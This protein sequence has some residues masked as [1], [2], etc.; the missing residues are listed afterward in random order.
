[1]HFIHLFFQFDLFQLFSFN[2][3]FSYYLFALRS[4]QIYQSFNSN[5]ILSSLVFF[6]H[7]PFWL[8]FSQTS[9]FLPNKDDK[10]SNVFYGHIKNHC[11]LLLNIFGYLFQSFYRNKLILLACCLI[12]FKENNCKGRIFYRGRFASIFQV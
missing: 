10:D 12:C 6:H 1:M 4:P 5:T 11:S 7:L 2:F 9:V 3:C 8:H